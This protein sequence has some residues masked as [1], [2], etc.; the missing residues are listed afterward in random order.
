MTR[1]ILLLL[2]A[3][4][5]LLPHVDHLGTG[6]TLPT[7]R[8]DV[9]ASYGKLPLSFEPNQGQVGARVSYLSRGRGF[10]LLLA[11]S[12]ALLSLRGEARSA[13]PTAVVRMRL[14]GGNT[15]PEVWAGPELPGKSHYFVGDDPRRWRTHVP[16]YARVT[17]R[18]VYPGVD[19]AFHGS[20]GRLEYDFL[21][22]PRVDPR[23]IRLR[24]EGPEDARLDETGKL[25][26][27]TPAG[28]LLQRAPYAYPCRIIDTRN[29]VGPLG[30]PP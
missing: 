20:Q 5:G 1:R 24:V 9:L 28:P 23:V 18:E 29:A 16:H 13:A 26:L 2:G 6:T 8:A 4:S 11:P 3:V 12:E 14:V 15:E 10:T 21:L 27:R 19:L 30:G 22:S 17:Y 25:V 7:A